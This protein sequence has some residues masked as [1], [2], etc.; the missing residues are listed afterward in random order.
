MVNKEISIS[1]RNVQEGDDI[2]IGITNGSDTSKVSI[3]NINNIGVKNIMEQMFGAM[4]MFT[5]LLQ[6]QQQMLHGQRV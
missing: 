6:M 1:A 3:V 4:A 2:T 5:W